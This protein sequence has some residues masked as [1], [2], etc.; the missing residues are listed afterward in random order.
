VEPLLALPVS[1]SAFLSQHCVSLRASD[2]TTRDAVSCDPTVFVY[3]LR[4]DDE[5]HEETTDED[6]GLVAFSQWR[7]PN[8]EFEGLWESL[9]FDGDTKPMLLHYA[10]TALLFSDA[11]IDPNIVSC[12]RVVLL[13]GPPGTGKTSLCK[14]LAQ[15]LAVRMGDQFAAGVLVEVN[16][17]SLFSKW[18]SES[19]KLV[20][21]LFSK[22]A[23]LVADSSLFV[24][25]LIDEVES[26]AAA[27]QSSL[28][29]SEPS[30]AIRVV[31]ALLTQL[32][33][34]KRHRNALV[35]TTSNLSDA[36]DPAFVDRAD[37]NCLVGHP[38]TEA[39]YAMLASCLA[40]MMRT[41]LVEPRERLFSF[42]TA[43]AVAADDPPSV[44]HRLL[45]LA[46]SCA[47]LS[48]RR[49]RKLP[50]LAYASARAALG[51][52]RVVD[53]A[54]FVAFLSDATLA[55]Q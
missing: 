41:G 37:I 40:E 10:E 47:G 1:Q 36:I 3:T 53:T 9:A 18:F 5:L 51:S 24:C 27:R 48:G 16:A 49:L 15:K 42:A 28:N 13:H 30:D 8:A 4:G 33:R 54:A 12:N 2:C 20:T 34:L 6:E 32:D 23:A 38:G 50:L 25:V 55:A 35:L 45:L 52:R 17:H 29:G 14:G 31:N 26:L 22:I 43:S 7:V 21:K 44:S 46:R 11:G 39:R 19:G